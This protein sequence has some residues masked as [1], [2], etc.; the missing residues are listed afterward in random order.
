MIDLCRK[1]ILSQSGKDAGNKSMSDYLKGLQEK[2]SKYVS[3]IKEEKEKPRP[4]REDYDL[5]L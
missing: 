2:Y 3:K 1:S 5:Y 4:E